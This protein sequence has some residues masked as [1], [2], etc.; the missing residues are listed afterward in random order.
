MHG[1][2]VIKYAI[3]DTNHIAICRP[4]L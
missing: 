1:N 2:N 4:F 3:L